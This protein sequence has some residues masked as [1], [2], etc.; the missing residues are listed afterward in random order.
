MSSPILEPYREEIFSMLRK[1]QSK[2]DV[3]RTIERK[4]G[5]KI[6]RSQFYAFAEQLSK[7]TTPE[8]EE[9][10]V[11]P[12]REVKVSET[13]TADETVQAFMTGLPRA[14]DEFTARL[15]TLEQQSREHEQKTLA[16]LRQCREEIAGYAKRVETLPARPETPSAPETETA[17]ESIPEHEQ[18]VA[19]DK[20]RSIWKRAFIVSGVF[21]A[22]I[23]LLLIRGYWRPLWET[24][25]KWIGFVEIIRL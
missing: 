19:T 15:T 17:P 4:H 6:S 9:E 7:D 20:L 18:T 11:M 12:L 10:R 23:E 22:A 2:A 14:F 16:G 1:G 8:N 21:W 25:G 24:L 5:V 3:W 13:P